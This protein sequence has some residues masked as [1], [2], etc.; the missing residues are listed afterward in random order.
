MAT[1]ETLQSDYLLEP[2]NRI[3]AMHGRGP[4]C[5]KD[6]QGESPTERMAFETEAIKNALALWQMGEDYGKYLTDNGVTTEDPFDLMFPSVKDETQ[7]EATF[8]EPIDIGSIFGG[9]DEA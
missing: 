9:D 8:N 7:E 2:I 1:I 3:M 5:F 4:V 6:N